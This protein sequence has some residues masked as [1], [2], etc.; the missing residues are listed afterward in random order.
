ME[1][2]AYNEYGDEAIRH[3]LDTM[4]K[5]NPDKMLQADLLT[6]NSRPYLSRVN[7][8]MLWNASMRTKIVETLAEKQEFYRDAMMPWMIGNFRIHLADRMKPATTLEELEWFLSNAA[9]FDAGF[10]LEFDVEAMRHH[11]LS[12]EMLDAVNLWEN[13][14]QT[15]AFTDAQK[16]L[17]KDP[18]A[19]WHLEK[20]DTA[21]CLYPQHVSRRY[22]CNLSD[23]RWTWNSPYESRF[24]LRIAVEGKGSISEL[25]FRTPNGILRFPCTVKAG[26]Y[27]IYNFDKTAFI[28]DANFNKLEEVTALGV[29]VL[30][31]GESEITFSCE[32]TPEGQRKPSVTVRYITR[33]EAIR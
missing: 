13:L 14:R 27:L 24:A 4:H 8:N 3:L 18:Y 23:D 7:E 33:G 29:S 20:A 26:Q 2:Y 12:D 17:F 9:A 22:L 11:G 1:S 10:G 25:E 16:E 32:V 28:T 15:Q 31:E 19:S 5:Y 30:D 6:P 21:F